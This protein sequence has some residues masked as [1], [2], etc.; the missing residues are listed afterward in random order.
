MGIEKYSQQ[1]GVSIKSVTAAVKNRAESSV[2]ADDTYKA[3]ACS[4]CFTPS[5][6]HSDMS[7]LVF[8][9]RSTAACLA[10]VTGWPSVQLL[11]G[12]MIG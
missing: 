2:P 11:S 6:V 1:K 10:V 7:A 12:T 8:C 4:A 9:C 5:Q 3:A